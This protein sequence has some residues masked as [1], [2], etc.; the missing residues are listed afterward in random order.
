MVIKIT[1]NLN[2]KFKKEKLSLIISG[3]NHVSGKLFF[4]NHI[5]LENLLSEICGF[6]NIYSY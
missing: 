1:L 4:I 5:V 6:L 3:N 2:L